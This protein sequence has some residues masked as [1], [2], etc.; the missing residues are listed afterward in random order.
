MDGVK[1]EINGIDLSQ[2]AQKIDNLT[3]ALSAKNAEPK[4][5]AN[6]E[7][8]LTR[9]EVAKLLRVTLPTINDWTNKGLIIAYRIGNR[10]RYKESEILQTI[11]NNKTK[12]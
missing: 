1:I 10:I 3:N 5:E 4:T 9:V 12:Q 8:L 7:T 2:L 6:G 11:T